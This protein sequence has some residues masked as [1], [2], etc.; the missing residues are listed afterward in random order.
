[1]TFQPLDL[2]QTAFMCAFIVALPT[3]PLARKWLTEVAGR[4]SVGTLQ[5]ERLCL[6]DKMLNW[7]SFGHLP[8][9]LSLSLCSPASYKQLSLPGNT[10]CLLNQRST[11]AGCTT[12]SRQQTP[13]GNPGCFVT[14]KKKKNWCIVSPQQCMR[15][16]VD[17]V[18]NTLGIYGL[19]TEP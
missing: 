16:M 11:P 8:D 5:K 7:P 1:M 4:A 3:T 2:L 10:T 13:D 6:A 15:V 17:A 9:P 19:S 14:K 18:V 12:S